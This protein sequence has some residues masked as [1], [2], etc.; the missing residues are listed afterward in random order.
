MHNWEE[1]DKL[2]QWKFIHGYPLMIFTGIIVAT[3]TVAY[4]WRRYKYSWEILQILVIIVIP[5]S[6]FGAKF[7]TL[8]FDGGWSNWYVLSGLSIYGALIFA[9]GSGITY[10]YFVRHAVDFRTVLS[11]VLPTILI[12]QAIGRWGNFFNHELYG[13]I[14]SGD[15]LNWLPHWIKSNMFI[16]GEYRQPIFLYESIASFTGYFLIVWVFNIKSTFK[17]G[18]TAGLYLIWYGIERI[19]LQTFR[20]PNPANTSYIGNS[21]IKLN[22]VVSALVITLGV[23]MFIWYEVLTKPIYKWI[24]RILPPKFL[25]Y[26]SKEY[27][28]IYPAKTKRFYVFA[29]DAETKKYNSFIYFGPPKDIIV[30]LFVPKGDNVKWSKRE[31]NKGRKSKRS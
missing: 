13:Q 8:V 29:R 18:T 7:Y 19:V 5:M 26:F 30:R 15:S 21:N 16:N 23:I 28:I 27:E 1:G 14:V 25:N 20:D 10:I 22:T 2:F 9:I 4:F 24:A 31:L 3:L 12:G 17:P 6:I 11:I